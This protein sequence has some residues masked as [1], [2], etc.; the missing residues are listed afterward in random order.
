MP[1]R[2]WADDED[3][4]LR[5]MA[6]AGATVAQ[7]A[8]ALRRTHDGVRGRC[9]RLHISIRRSPVA[10]SRKPGVLTSGLFLRASRVAT[11][12]DTRSTAERKHDL[13]QR[14]AKRHAL[15]EGEVTKIFGNTRDPLQ[16]SEIR[17]K[18]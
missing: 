2:L 10:Q 3:K 6:A 17:R 9:D 11:N 8:R 1:V 5:R 14:L 15:T 4:M 16:S 7:I 18:V 12:I 13:A